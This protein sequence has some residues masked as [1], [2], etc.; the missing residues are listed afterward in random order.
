MEEGKGEEDEEREELDEHG[1][2]FVGLLLLLVVVRPSCG[3]VHTGGAEPAWAEG[4]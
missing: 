1:A 3:G 4:C 2:R